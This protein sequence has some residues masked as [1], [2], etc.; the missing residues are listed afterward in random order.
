MEFRIRAKNSKRGRREHWSPSEKEDD[1][2]AEERG[3][4]KRARLSLKLNHGDIVIM[5]GEKIQTIWEHAAIPT[6]RF[7]IAATARYISEENSKKPRPKPTIKTESSA[8]EEDLEM[9]LIPEIG[10]T[11]DAFD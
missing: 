9:S 3:E 10:T 5:H 6:G 7:R 2:A 11:A 4:K 1:K 8:A